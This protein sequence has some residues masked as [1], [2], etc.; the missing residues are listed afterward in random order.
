MP[1]SPLFLDPK[2][3]STLLEYIRNGNHIR[4]ACRAVGIHPNTYVQWV[5][6]AEYKDRRN[7]NPPPPELIEFIDKVREAEA[8]C[9]AEI[10]KNVRA[11]AMD[12][13]EIGLKF[14]SRRYPERWGERKEIHNYDKDWR[15]VALGMLRRGEV[16]LEALEESLPK[17]LYSEVAKMIEPPQEESTEGE[18]KELTS[19]DV[20][21]ITEQS[22]TGQ[23][24]PSPRQV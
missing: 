1:P 22:N 4:V 23:A 12:D 11:E 8:A 15:V 19:A 9:E 6:W 14:L 2:T 17:E 20:G 13:A 5:R 10:V 24:R 18:F 3:Q 16:T 7:P 21:S